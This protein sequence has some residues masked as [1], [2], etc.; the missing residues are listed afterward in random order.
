MNVAAIAEE[1]GITLS[2]QKF[3]SVS[4]L[5]ASRSKESAR[6]LSPSVQEVFRGCRSELKAI[7]Q[8]MLGTRTGAE[9]RRE[10]TRLFPKYLG[11]SLAISYFS[12]AVVPRDVIEADF[13]EKGLSAFGASIRSQALF[14][15]WTLRKINEI[16]TQ[17]SASKL[18]ESKKQEDILACVQFTVNVLRAKMALDCLQVAMNEQ[19]AIYPGVSDELLDDLRSMVN[20]YSWA[21]KGLEIRVTTADA[22]LEIPSMD[23]EDRELLEVA[24]ASASELSEGL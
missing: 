8:I 20:A 13:R 15:I 14:T 16:V 12:S 1:F 5:L 18:D 7:Q 4:S 11:L 3:E 6:E 24:F 19:I 23:D 21:R 2:N 17:I 22:I 10:F 9:H